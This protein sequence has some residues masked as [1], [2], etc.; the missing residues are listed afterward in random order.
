MAVCTEISPALADSPSQ[1]TITD[2]SRI[3]LT[4]PPFPP[5][6]MSH[7]PTAYAPTP[8]AT[9]IPSPSSSL[10]F[11]WS[12]RTA[13][14]SP[15]WVPVGVLQVSP[16]RLSLSVLSLSLFIMRWRWYHFS[17]P[18]AAYRRSAKHRIVA[19][20]VL[21]I[22]SRGR[23]NSDTSVIMSRKR[24]NTLPTTDL[25]THATIIN[26]YATGSAGGRQQRKT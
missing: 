8:P 2:P 18:L 25:L 12:S 1:H 7:L 23:Q 11:Q 24:S 16:D 10:Q 22:I 5:P 26:I 15:Y 14:S 17:S 9:L 4:L 6:T 19:S 3:V 20:S 21:A 13:R